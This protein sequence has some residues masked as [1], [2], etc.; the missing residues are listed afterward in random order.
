M[1]YLISICL[2]MGGTMLQAQKAAPKSGAPA[3]TSNKVNVVVQI[4][5]RPTNA[6]S[7]GVFEFS[8]L[9]A[10]MIKRGGLRASDSA[11]V[12]ELPAG[13]PRIIGI[14]Y[15]NGQLMRL[16]V[17]EEPEIKAFANF[18]YMELGRS[19]SPMNM[20][21]FS[22]I[23]KT[24][25]FKTRT[26]ELR[27]KYFTAPNV[28]TS[29]EGKAAVK[30]IA[31]LQKE[32]QHF[33]DSLKT[34]NPMLG[35]IAALMIAPEYLHEQPVKKTEA[36]FYAKDYFRFV[37]FADPAYDGLPEIAKA[38][39]N[40]VR[41]L[42]TLS[43][44]AEKQQAL[45][46]EYLAKWKPASAAHRLALGGIVGAY[47]SI[48]HQ[49]YPTYAKL[50]VD[51]Y[52]SKDNGEI[53]QLEY[54]L[55]RS[56]TSVVGGEAPDLIGNTPENATYALSQLR[57]KVVLIDFWAS[58]CGPCIREIPAV[59]KA[60]DIYH[61]KGFDI[62]GVSLDRDAEAWKRAISQHQLPWHHISD[63]KGWQSEHAALYS[64]TSIPQTLLLDRQ[65]RIIA[66]NLRGE[67]L[68]L[69]LREVFGE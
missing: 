69:K 68:E 19:S 36:D 67:Q 59:K 54:D 5:G 37:N 30:N 33:V 23:R 60:Y 16:V 63:L 49:L 12:V 62:L 42:Q 57:G 35:R 41:Q 45:L 27:G 43:M 7:I 26:E 38:F 28:S 46:N 11:Y 44:A 17:G 58:W 8:G 24:E 2:L 22:T 39:D 65:G 32:K 56:G 25:E 47:Q 66:R 15:N 4:Y 48:N 20:A 55:R 21:Y 10:K 14:G 61:P 51:T 6:D 29:L 31:A 52:K 40:L 53:P 13:K 3:K 50:Y 18:Q 64:V 34:A 1:K 9:G